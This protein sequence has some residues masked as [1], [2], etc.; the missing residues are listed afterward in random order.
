MKLGFGIAA[1]CSRT[2]RKEGNDLST[3]EG[4]KRGELCI[5]SVT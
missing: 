2:K 5:N 3:G 1:F 4:I